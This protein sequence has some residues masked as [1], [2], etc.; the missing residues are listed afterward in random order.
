MMAYLFIACII[1]YGVYLGFKDKYKSAGA[2][3]METIYLS[4]PIFIVLFCVLVFREFW[5]F[6]TPAAC[7]YC[8]YR[9]VRFSQY[10]AEIDPDFVPFNY[11]TYQIDNPNATQ[12]ELDAAKE[13]WKKEL[14]EQALNEDVLKAHQSAV[15]WYHNI[16]WIWA[17]GALGAGFT[18]ATAVA[19][20]YMQMGEDPAVFWYVCLI[21]MCT[22]AFRQFMRSSAI[23]KRENKKGNH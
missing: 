1:I 14:D 20:P 19:V 23:K 13:R 2:R 6:A 18:T 8:Y 4:V 22:L 9:Y 21:P 16:Q 10:A 17:V 7:G 3:V 15:K 12:E 11:I 5:L